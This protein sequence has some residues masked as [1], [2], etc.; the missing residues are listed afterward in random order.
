MIVSLFFFETTPCTKIW[1]PPS[2]GWTHLVKIPDHTT[3]WKIILRKFV[4]WFSS[5]CLT[6]QSP[7]FTMLLQPNS[8]WWEPLGFEFLGPITCMNSLSQSTAQGLQPSPSRHGLFPHP[9]SNV[10]RDGLLVLSCASPTT[11]LNSPQRL[12][13][14]P[15]VH[16]SMQSS[17]LQL[18]ITRIKFP[19]STTH[20]GSHGSPD[21][22]SSNA[23]S[24][25]V[26]L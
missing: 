17:H 5:L 14:S 26:L 24:S 18:K 1:F 15:V 2:V 20:H 8:P 6:V 3:S 13:P 10:M 9:D 25:S 21:L 16:H 12:K 22:C 7:W 11:V 19:Y 4:P 23:F